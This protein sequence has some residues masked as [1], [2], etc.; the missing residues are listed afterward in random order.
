MSAGTLGVGP[1]AGGQNILRLT[2]NGQV[3]PSYVAA[4]PSAACPGIFTSA[5][6]LQHDVEADA[7][8]LGVP[9]AAQ[10]V[11][12]GRQRAAAHRR[13]RRDRALP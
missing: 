10:P 11:H 3:K 9:A 12:R 1:N 5:T 7:E 6:G 2:E 13:H 4:H 8:G